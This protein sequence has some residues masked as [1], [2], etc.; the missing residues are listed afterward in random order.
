MIFF[1]VFFIREMESK[2]AHYNPWAIFCLTL[3]VILS[4]KDWLKFVTHSA[5]NT[6]AICHPVVNFSIF[7]SNDV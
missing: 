3:D 5:E 4:V 7:F 2:D 1:P 6:E